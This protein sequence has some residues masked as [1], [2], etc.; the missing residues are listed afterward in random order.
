MRKR[1]SA[2]ARGQHGA[3]PTVIVSAGNYKNISQ[4]SAYTPPIPWGVDAR[5]PGG[6]VARYVSDPRPDPTPGLWR[7]GRDGVPEKISPLALVR[8]TVGRGEN[9]EI[10]AIH[11]KTGDHY[12]FEGR[13]DDVVTEFHR[14]GARLGIRA[15]RDRIFWAITEFV[16]AVRRRAEGRVA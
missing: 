3:L 12:P 4:R 7:T 16:Q 6:R 15:P 8:I 2:P 9:V 10:L 13:I 5:I 14:A 1:G 11:P